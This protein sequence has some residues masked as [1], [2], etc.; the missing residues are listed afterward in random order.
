M[1]HQI[2]GPVFIKQKVS[3][4]I[5]NDKKDNGYWSLKEIC[6]KIGERYGVMAGVD[7]REIILK[8]VVGIED[9]ERYIN[10]SIL[11]AKKQKQMRRMTN[12]NKKLDVFKN[13]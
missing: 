2:N 6:L 1:E 3:E 5:I 12:Q 4:Y 11:S 7:A 9:E 8:E 13:I 10:D